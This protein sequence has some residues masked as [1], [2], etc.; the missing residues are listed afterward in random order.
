MEEREYCIEHLTA[1]QL[2]ARQAGDIILAYL[3]GMALMHAQGLGDED[4]AEIDEL[5]ERSA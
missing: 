3:I 2:L 4:D 1:A 5:A